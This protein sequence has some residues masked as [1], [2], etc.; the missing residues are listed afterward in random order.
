DTLQAAVLLAKM[1]I[2]EEEVQ[3]R[4]RIGARYSELIRDAFKNSSQQ[5]TTPY[6]APESTSVYAQY[7]IE[8]ENREKVAARLKAHDIPTAVHYPVPLHFQPVFASLGQG[9]G[10][11]PVAEKAASR[12]LS[13]PMHPYLSE[14]QQANVVEALFA[15]VTGA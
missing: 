15:A 3:A 8:V 11:F 10:S 2:F 1:E 6:V 12:V 9:P 4:N 13:L 14:A 7:T 5:V